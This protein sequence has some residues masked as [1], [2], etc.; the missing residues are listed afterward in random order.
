M[1]LEVRNFYNFDLYM[2]IFAIKTEGVC[3]EL[4]KLGRKWK[5][6]GPSTRSQ[7]NPLFLSRTERTSHGYR[8]PHASFLHDTKN[9][10]INFDL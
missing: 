7:R 9:R 4:S 6:E 2:C 1:K 5:G 8:H 10:D 3:A